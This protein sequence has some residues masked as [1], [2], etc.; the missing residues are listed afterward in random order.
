MRKPGVYSVTLDLYHNGRVEP[1][2][3]PE[4]F[5]VFPLEL[6]TMHADDPEGVLAFAREA[7]DLRREVIGAI[8]AAGECSTK[9]RNSGMRCHITSEPKKR[10]ALPGGVYSR[11]MGPGSAISRSTP[12]ARTS[13]HRGSKAP[14][15]QA[16][17]SSR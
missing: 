12:A 17:P 13:S 15:R 16:T 9:S 8:R 4:S 14:R 2:A 3:G 10:P 7:S 6:A 5:E 11:A 1:L